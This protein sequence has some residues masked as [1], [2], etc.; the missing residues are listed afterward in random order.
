[1]D[2][3]AKRVVR[4]YGLQD[5]DGDIDLGRKVDTEEVG[6]LEGLVENWEG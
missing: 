4:N 1:M 6:A 3:V 5:A 2:G